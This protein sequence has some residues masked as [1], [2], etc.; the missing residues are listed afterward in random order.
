M[1]IPGRCLVLAVVASVGPPLAVHAY[2]G[3]GSTS[4][5]V[6]QEIPGSICTEPTRDASQFSPRLWCQ[7]RLLRKRCN[8]IDRCLI[9]CHM[10][11]DGKG[12]GGGCL[13]WCQEELGGVVWAP[14][15]GIPYCFLMPSG[16]LPE[17]RFRGKPIDHW[18]GRLRNSN[19]AIRRSTIQ[20]IVASVGADLLVPALSEALRDS[21]QE[22]RVGATCGK[23]CSSCLLGARYCRNSPG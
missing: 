22:V 19:V 9:D 8:K 4:P 5:G 2:P 1:H 20:R 15:E 16:E 14:P 18:Q 17:P 21:D 10:T 7:L 6:G 13:R 3:N 12:I 23:R 11:D